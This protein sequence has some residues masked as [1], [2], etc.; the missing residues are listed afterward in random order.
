MT[1]MSLVTCLTLCQELWTWLAANAEKEKFDWPRWQE[2]DKVYPEITGRA[3]FCPCCYYTIEVNKEGCDKCPLLP[4][5]GTEIFQTFCPHP[6]LD[7]FDS[8]YHLWDCTPGSSKWRKRSAQT[9]ADYCT[10]ALAELEKSK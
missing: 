9:I 8:P 3:C 5:W 6:C 7:N 2:L 4:L 10:K 1:E